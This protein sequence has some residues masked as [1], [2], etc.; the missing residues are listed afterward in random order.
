MRTPIDEYGAPEGGCVKLH[1]AHTRR[2]WIALLLALTALALAANAGYIH[3]KA[4]LAQ[5]LLQRAW[6]AAQ[7][8][9]AAHRP[10]PWADS[11]PVARLEMPRLGVDQIVLAGDSGRTIAFGPGWAEA[12]ASPGATGTTVISGHRDTHFD[13]LQAL[14]PNDELTLHAADGARHYRVLSTHIADSSADRLALTSDDDHLVLVTCWPFDAV[15][16]GGALRYV[17]VAQAADPSPLLA[18]K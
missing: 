8:D 5:V 7:I 6:Q 14:V 10:W 2:R 12:S 18:A 9:H 16:A 3:A 1:S 17:V 11:H 13:W 15:A 4:A